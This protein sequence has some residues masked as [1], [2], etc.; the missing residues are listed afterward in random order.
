MAAGGAV[1]GCPR[2]DLRPDGGPKRSTRPQV[3]V[4]VP[5]SYSILLHSSWWSAA[6]AGASEARFAWWRVGP[7]QQPC[8]ARAGPA[9]Q[10]PSATRAARCSA[11]SLTRLDLVLETQTPSFTNTGSPSPSTVISSL[12]PRGTGRRGRDVPLSRPHAQLG[13]PPLMLLRE[14]R[15]RIGLPLQPSP[16]VVALELHTGLDLRQV[17]V[18]VDQVGKYAVVALPVQRPR[19]GPV[20]VDRRRLLRAH[21]DPLGVLPKAALPAEVG[22][23]L[24]EGTIAAP[25]PPPH[26]ASCRGARCPVARR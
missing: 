18:G 6:A 7:G 12:C 13:Q 19:A 9:Q 3:Q 2:R 17:T 21:P 23:V 22:H 15:P 26:T 14:L 20:R 11:V 25:A 16:E 5:P 4:Q 10:M 8:V 1:R 24:P